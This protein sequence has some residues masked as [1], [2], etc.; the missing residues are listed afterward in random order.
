MKTAKEILKDEL[1][2]NLWLFIC[3]YP[4]AYKSDEMLVDWIADAMK[5]YAS[6]QEPLSEKKILDVLD[7]FDTFLRKRRG[8]QR[9]SSDEADMFTT[10]LSG[11]SQ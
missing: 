7:Q 5:Q 3:A 2:E 4:V 9:F 8:G 10:E 1:S 6:Q 11:K